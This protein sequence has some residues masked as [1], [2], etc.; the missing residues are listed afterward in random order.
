MVTCL[1]ARSISTPWAQGTAGLARQ[2]PLLPRRLMSILCLWR[3]RN[4]SVITWTASKVRADVYWKTKKHWHR[5]LYVQAWAEITKTLAH[6]GEGCQKKSQTH[7][8]LDK[9]RDLPI[10][11]DPIS[12]ESDIVLICLFSMQCMRP[13][14]HKN[15]KNSVYA[16]SFKWTPLCL[17][18]HW[19]QKYHTHKQ[20]QFQGQE[21]RKSGKSVAYAGCPATKILALM[22]F[23]SL[24]YFHVIWNLFTQIFF[25]LEQFKSNGTPYELMLNEQI[26][27]WSVYQLQDTP[28]LPEPPIVGQT[29]PPLDHQNLLSESQTHLHLHTEF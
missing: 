18:S 22:L 5:V 14:F 1:R 27:L 16:G 2:S 8:I 13:G 19:A 6:W 9:N 11:K 23:W 7:K 17:F 20:R 28:S 21:D 3:K 25:S 26:L 15:A 29:W 4:A 12:E 10:I 24:E